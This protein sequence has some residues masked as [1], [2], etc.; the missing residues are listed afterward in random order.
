MRWGLGG[1][2][3]GV[4]AEGGSGSSRA[5]NGG[6]SGAGTGGISHDPASSMAC[7]ATDKP[8]AASKRV[9]AGGR[10]MAGLLQLETSDDLLVAGAVIFNNA[11]F[12]RQQPVFAGQPDFSGGFA[13]SMTF[14]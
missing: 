2:G 12:H 11:H 13:C 6:R 7:A 14:D 8:A 4:A 5:V 9:G 1:A 3:G 10:Y